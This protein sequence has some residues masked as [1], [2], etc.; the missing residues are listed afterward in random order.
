[1]EPFTALKN[2]RSIT[3][4]ALGYAEELGEL[5]SLELAA[6][7]SRLIRRIAAIAVACLAF[8]CGFLFVGVA[9]LSAFWDSSS[10]TGVA[11]TIAIVYMVIAA[12]LILVGRSGVRP[13]DRTRDELQRSM[14]W[15]KTHL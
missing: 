12:M 8:A 1:M 13:M 11:I 5:A 3:T 14:Q 10:R 6:A 15:L 4:E 9:V 7:Q 2:W